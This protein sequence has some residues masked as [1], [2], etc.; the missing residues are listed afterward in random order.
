MRSCSWAARY[1]GEAGD[2]PNDLNLLVVGS[3]QRSALARIARDLEPQLGYEINP[4]VVPAAQWEAKKSGFLQSVARGPL[5][6]L[7]LIG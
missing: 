2:A 7:D 4:T 1:L 3:P 5:V 6:E